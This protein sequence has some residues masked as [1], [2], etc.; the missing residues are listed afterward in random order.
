MAWPWV[1]AYRGG[2]GEW[3]GGWG[4]GMGTMVCLPSAYLEGDDVVVELWVW[5]TLGQKM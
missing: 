2:C 1:G 4:G 5:V 3:V